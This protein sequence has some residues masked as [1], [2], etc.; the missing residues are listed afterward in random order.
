M[1]RLVLA[2]IILAAAAFPASAQN[3]FINIRLENKL[4]E[5]PAVSVSV[6]DVKELLEQSFGK[7]VS[8]NGKDAEIELILRVGQDSELSTARDFPS[9]ILYPVQFYKWKSGPSDEG[10]AL[11]LTA[12]S[13][14]G[15]VY[16]LYGLLTEKLGFRFYHPK[17][18]YIPAHSNWPLPGR[19]TFEA[20]PR[21]AKRGFHLHT[22]HP[23][24]LTEQLHSSMDGTAL[25]DVKEY[26][27]WLVRNGQNV[28]QFWLL[29]T[30]DREKWPVYARQFVQYAKMRGV[31]TGAV[32]SLSTLQQKAFQTVNLL[33]PYKSYK[34]QINENLDWLMQVP[35]DFISIDFTMGE[36]LPDLSVLMPGSKNYLIETIKEKYGVA[37]ME[38][39]H[40]I[41]R[42]HS[43]T[44]AEAGKIIHS[45]MFY[46]ISEE[47]APV[48]GN[49]NQQF[50]YD[51]MQ[52]A[53]TERETWYW[54]ESSYWVTFDT[55][56][57]LFL[58]PYLK[59][60]YDDIM[61]VADEG[62]DGHVTFT[63]GWEW[64]YWIIDYSIARWTWSYKENGNPVKTRPTEALSELFGPETDPLFDG[65]MALQEKYLKDNK[66][67]SLLSARTPFEELPWPFNRSFQPEGGYSM[68]KASIPFIGKKDRLKIEE[69]A[70]LL[71]S[72]YSKLSG[73][74]D[75]IRE[76]KQFTGDI[77]DS[78]REELLNSLSITALR[79]EHRYYTLMA[80]A[81]RNYLLSDS[82][83]FY[84]DNLLKGAAVTRGEAM[85]IVKQMEQDYRY[86]VALIAR[87]MYSHTSYD[88]GYLYPVSDLFFWQREEKQ[89]A[90]T[91]FD[92]FYMNLW[93][94]WDTLGL[95]GLFK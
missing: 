74:T 8:I 12:G 39:T 59:S 94:F 75:E 51:M 92:A 10:L 63:S 54:P 69:S 16:G 68:V 1:I 21:F 2:V 65:A 23:M 25:D 58:L 30:V 40:V 19:F 88:F 76:H 33:K 35:F 85:S 49:E 89:V 87:K 86:P 14:M 29:R 60:R 78:L 5:I 57:P 9:S 20:E 18:T 22:M 31:M 66:L 15:L 13:E 53:K 7:S 46:S 62:I 73:V 91:R 47:D 6:R 26:A 11:T 50:M 83:R 71:K 41:K 34:T 38:N 43:E 90:G 77:R 3:N 95:D 67:I 37:V 36:Y 17:D 28:M 45:V 79:A 72:F 82:S 27:D 52:E 81:Y 70:E 61:L 44:P 24:E 80:G 42:R 56:V 93:N 32:I 55:S 4:F 48:Y 84:V 64:G